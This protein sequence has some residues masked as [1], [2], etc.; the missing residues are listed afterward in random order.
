MGTLCLALSRISH[1][2]GKAGVST[3]HAVCTKNSGPVS[4]SCQSGG[5]AGTLLTSSSQTPSGGWASLYGQQTACC[6]STPKVAEPDL[7]PAIS[8]SDELPFHAHAG[9]RLGDGALGAWGWLGGREG[10][11]R[12]KHSSFFRAGLSPPCP[13]GS[14]PPSLPLSLLAPAFPAWSRRRVDISKHSGRGRLCQECGIPPSVP[15]STCP[16]PH[17]SPP[18][19]RTP[20]LG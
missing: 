15:S 20:Q 13:A 9:G 12:E 1:F 10:R 3:E 5:G 18:W 4:R 7:P 14:P 2:R 17:D 11:D 16:P 6:V 19:P 8:S